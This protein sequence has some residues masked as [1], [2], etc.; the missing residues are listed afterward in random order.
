[1]KFEKATVTRIE[2]EEEDIIV[3]SGCGTALSSLK[4]CDGHELGA[5]G[6]LC[7]FNPS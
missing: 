7:G 6:T 5:G 4:E 3:T 1:M 2:I